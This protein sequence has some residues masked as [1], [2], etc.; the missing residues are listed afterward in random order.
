MR[1]YIIKIRFEDR[2]YFNKNSLI[3]SGNIFILSQKNGSKIFVPSQTPKLLFIDDNF[4]L[5]NQI[6]FNAIYPYKI[7][8]I[9]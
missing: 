8:A 3:L 6:I 9:I 4:I 5:P 7:Q 1:F 2:N